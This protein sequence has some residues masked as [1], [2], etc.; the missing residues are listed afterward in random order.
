MRKNEDQMRRAQLIKESKIKINHRNI[1]S[2]IGA[3][4]KQEQNKLISAYTNKYGM[5]TEE[6][7]HR[8]C[9]T[10]TKKETAHTL[11]A[12]I[13]QQLDEQAGQSAYEKHIK[14]KTI[15]K[16]I[17]SLVEQ[18]R[19]LEAYALRPSESQINTEQE[20]NS[21]INFCFQQL[22]KLED[23]KNKVASGN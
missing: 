20:A 5:I 21:T 19:F 4:V 23:E 17:E 9:P 2:F 16:E 14:Q 7:V 11:H 15:E 1:E 22:Q 10:K 13:I 12:S 6:E 8:V 3:G 18:R